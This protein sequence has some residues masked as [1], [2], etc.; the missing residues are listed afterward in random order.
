MSCLLD[1]PIVL[2]GCKVEGIIFNISRKQTST[3]ESHISVIQYIFDGPI[4]FDGW[5]GEGITYKLSRK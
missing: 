2:E 1:G 5:K 4:A 3:I